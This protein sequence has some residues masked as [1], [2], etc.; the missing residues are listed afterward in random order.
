VRFELSPAEVERFAT[1]PVVLAV[2]HPQYLE[3]TTLSDDTRAAL[4]EDLRAS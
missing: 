1:E 4:L 2:N 3:G